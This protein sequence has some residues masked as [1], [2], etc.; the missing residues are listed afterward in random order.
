MIKFVDL[1]VWFELGER[2]KMNRVKKEGGTPKKGKLGS[3][4]QFSL[5]LLFF[6]NL[7][8]WLGQ[9]CLQTHFM[10]CQSQPR[11]YYYKPTG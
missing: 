8:L 5:G 2:G 4:L 6:L 11:E 7:S 1:F 3:T 9:A 10:T